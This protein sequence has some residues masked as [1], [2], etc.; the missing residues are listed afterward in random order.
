[1]TGTPGTEFLERYGVQTAGGRVHQEYWI[2]AED[3]PAFNAN[4]AGEIE[5]I[6]EF[7][8]GQ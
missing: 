3:L 8:G 6:A 1:V 5:V 2:P 4:I 7:H